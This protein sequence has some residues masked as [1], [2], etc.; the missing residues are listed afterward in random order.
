MEN[1]LSK[2]IL[3]ALSSNNIR[4]ISLDELARIMHPAASCDFFSGLNAIEEERGI[5]AELLDALLELDRLE[6]II[7]DEDTDDCMLAKEALKLRKTGTE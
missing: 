3:K 2:K 7:L 6:L 4:K 5:Q 1:I